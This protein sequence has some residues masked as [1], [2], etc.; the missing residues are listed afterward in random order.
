MG[1]GPT[2]GMPS[3]GVFLRHPSPYLIEKTTENSELVGRQT[4]PGIEPEFF[5]R[6]SHPQSKV[7]L[8]YELQNLAYVV[9]WS[10]GFR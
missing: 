5:M 10:P 2:G 8:V 3:M 6:Q 7:P 9:H 1:P 4:R